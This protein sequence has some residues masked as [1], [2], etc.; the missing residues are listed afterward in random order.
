MTASAGFFAFVTV[1]TSADHVWPLSVERT[2]CSVQSVP[3][4]PPTRSHHASQTALELLGSTA[5]DRS[6]PSRSCP[7]W[8]LKRMKRLVA[9]SRPAMPSLGS[10]SARERRGARAEAV[11]AR[12][13][14]VDLEVGAGPARPAVERGV[15]GPVG[16]PGDPDRRP[17]LAAADREMTTV[18][19]RSSWIGLKPAGAAAV[20][21][22][23][24]RSTVAV[25]PPGWLPSSLPTQTRSCGVGAATTLPETTQGWSS[26]GAV[27][28]HRHR[29]RGRERARCAGSAGGWSRRSGCRR[30]AC[31]SDVPKPTVMSRVPTSGSLPGTTVRSDQVL[32]PSVET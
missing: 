18:E 29:R 31:R 14:D 19:R 32:P 5:I 21:A 7:I 1:R 25:R 16:M 30:R 8:A 13:R 9:T 4:A 24:E 2:T 26:R 15:D 3:A 17:V 23:G 28:Q 27:D 22:S 11:V 6:P 12:D 20:P 10:V